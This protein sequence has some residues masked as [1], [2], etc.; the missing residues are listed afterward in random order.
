MR[1]NII[2]IKPIEVIKSKVRVAAYIRVSTNKED[3]QSSFA[4]QYIHYKTLFEDSI[5]E[6]LIDMYSDE[7]IGRA[8]V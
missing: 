7:E 6:E 5:T 8:H 3:Q 2:P 4:A 1:Q